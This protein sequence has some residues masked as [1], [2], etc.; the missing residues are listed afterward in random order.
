MLFLNYSLAPQ[1]PSSTLPIGEAR[2]LKAN[3]IVPI[4]PT[5]DFSHSILALSSAK[6][7]EQLLTAPICGFV[8]V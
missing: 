3:K 4:A 8:H 5:A 1:A 7:P 6:D 2:L